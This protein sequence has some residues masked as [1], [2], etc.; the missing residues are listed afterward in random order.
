MESKEHETK[1]IAIALSRIPYLYLSSE[2]IVR[3]EREHSEVRVKTIRCNS[4]EAFRKVEKRECE[5]GIVAGLPEGFD[6]EKYDT[7]IIGRDTLRLAVPN[8]QK[9]LCQKKTVTMGEILSR[10][11]VGDIGII[12]RERGSETREFA[13]GLFGRDRNLVEKATAM[14]LQSNEEIL[15]AVSRSAR[16]SVQYISLVSSEMCEDLQPVNAALIP[17]EECQPRDFV[18]IRKSKD[19]RAE[20]LWTFLTQIFNVKSRLKETVELIEKNVK[21]QLPHEYLRD[22]QLNCDFCVKDNDVH[23]RIFPASSTGVE[24]VW[25]CSEHELKRY[26]G[27]KHPWYNLHFRFLTQS[28]ARQRRLN[29]KDLISNPRFGEMISKEILLRE[30]WIRQIKTW[31]P[32]V[33]GT[34]LAIIGIVIGLR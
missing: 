2:T 8:T 31:A 4:S 15:A 7:I 27:L 17:V 21:D 19:K 12:L 25:E 13:L 6:N 5:V 10:L 34:I 33:I 1:E 20:P 16:Y 14:T 3:F 28:I 9:P 24:R 22:R 18:A 23:Y 11:R 26:K 29:R 32:V 30:T